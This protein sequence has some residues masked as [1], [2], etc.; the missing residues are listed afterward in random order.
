MNKERIMSRTSNAFG[1]AYRPRMIVE[2]APDALKAADHL[3]EHGAPLQS[4]GQPSL[5]RDS[6]LSIEQF[7]QFDE[8]FFFPDVSDVIAEDNQIYPFEVERLDV[9]DL[10]DAIDLNQ[11][12]PFEGAND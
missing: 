7:D 10:V 12:D 1:N 2:H 4:R 8:E 5:R 6:D 9:D 3:A 11:Q